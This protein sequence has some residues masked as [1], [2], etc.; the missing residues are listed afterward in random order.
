MDFALIRSA[1][2]VPGTRPDRVDKALDTQADAVIID[3]EDAA[4]PEKKAE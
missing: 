2:F 3:L 1:L 4:P